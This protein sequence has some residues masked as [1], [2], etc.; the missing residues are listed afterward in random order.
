LVGLMSLGIRRWT[1]L[2]WPAWSIQF[3]IVTLIIGFT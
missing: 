3:L 2:A 1:G